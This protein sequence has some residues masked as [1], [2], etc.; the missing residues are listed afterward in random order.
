MRRRAAVVELITADM[1]LLSAVALD[2]ADEARTALTDRWRQTARLLIEAR[3]A[4]RTYL[5]TLVEH[6]IPTPPKA[7]VPGPTPID[8]AIA[9]QLALTG[10]ATGEVAAKETVELYAA[11]VKRR[12]DLRDT[13][14]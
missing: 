10:W 3:A 2:Q 6:S 4:E 5:S 14:G 8:R 12:G 11:E 1:G 7:D 9:L 13:I